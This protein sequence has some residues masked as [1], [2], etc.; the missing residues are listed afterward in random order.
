MLGEVSAVSQY[1]TPARVSPPGRIVQHELDARGWTQTDLAEIIKRPVQAVNEIIRG[2]KQ[3]TP[4]T[5]LEL[6][7]AFGTSAQFWLNLE[8]NYRLWLNGRN[9]D[10]ESIKKR[11]KLYALLPVRELIRRGWLPPTNSADELEQAVYDFLGVTERTDE[12]LAMV[13]NFRCSPG[14]E[15]D[16][17]S[18][19]AWVKRV[20]QL[21]EE[22]KT[23][24]FSPEKLVKNL[25][26]ILR[27][28][29]EKA[30]VHKVPEILNNYGIRFVLV[31][32]LPKTYIDGAAFYLNGCPVIALSLR[33]DR[34]DSFWFNLCHEISHILYGH[35]Q[36]F[37][38]VNLNDGETEGK[39]A[40][41]SEEENEANDR[42]KNWLIDPKAYQQFL[43]AVNKQFF[44]RQAI[45]DFAK[46]QHRHPGVI[47]GRLQRD[48]YVPYRNLR[49]LLPK[50]TP[51][52]DGF[53]DRA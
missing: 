17:P 24:P 32:H 43:R 28:F 9:I 41:S 25:P 49:N 46:A 26:E 20:E 7:A 8:V 4:E 18:K 35:G 13:V 5:A 37:L 36:S 48:G 47:L 31:P 45:I 10:A 14:K 33:Y 51:F 1:N 42:A 52:L 27:S 16:L 39:E 38:D 40:I 15:P 53:F 30:N 19:L 21:A 22:K 29:E 44:S 34:V 11:G 3:I 12:A 23:P 50:V 6:A 2:N